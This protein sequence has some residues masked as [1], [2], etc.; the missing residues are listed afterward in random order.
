MNAAD[1]IR[2]ERNNFHYIGGSALGLDSATH[3]NQVIGNVFS[4]ISSNAINIDVTLNDNTTD[5]RLKIQRQHH[6]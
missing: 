6:T 2:F 5:T 3:D 1:S 4:G